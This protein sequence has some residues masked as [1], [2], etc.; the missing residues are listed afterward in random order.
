MNMH[1]YFLGIDNGGTVAK[2]AIFDET[3]AEIAIA[4]ETVPFSSPKPGFVE[5]DM[6]ALW[7]ANCRI[8]REV[9]QHS[10]IPSTHI[11][12]VACTGH[13]KGLYLW[14]KEEH[15]AYPGI[16]STDTRAWEYPLRWEKNGTAHAVYAKTFQRILACQPV[17][18]LAWLKDHAPEVVSRT[19]WI[20]EAK[21]FIRFML[22]G[23]AQAEITDYSGSG[24]LNIRDRCFDRDLL[25]AY[26]LSDIYE[27]LPP[28]VQSTALCGKISA[29]AARATGLMEGTPV[30][31]GMFD[32][33]ACAVASGV[34]DERYVGVVA[35][36]WSINEYVSKRPVTD[37][38]IMMNS[39]F[40]IPEYYLIEESSPTSAG[41]YEW[42]I[43]FFL[44]KEKKEANET[45]VSIFELAERMARSVASEECDLVFLPFLFGSN[46]NPEARACFVG[47]SAR[48]TRAH[49]IRAVLE[50]IAFSHKTHIDKL[51]A[52]RT[53]PLAIRLTGGAAKSK[54]WVQIF[55]DVIG[56]PVETVLA[57][58]PGALGC[59]MSA[60][61]AS[62]LYRDLREAV[63]HMVR[64]GER[65]EPGANATEMYQKKYNIY[66]DIADSLD[67]SWKGF[68]SQIP[69]TALPS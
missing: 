10:Q 29:S 27:K 37:G 50:G 64:R 11:A 48:H 61:V 51:S 28:L 53:P 26:G 65:I 16:V 52:T 20:F 49:M 12:A 9:L 58:E 41:N 42:F 21:D 32:I 8:I 1:H 2:A 57:S 34:I 66:K 60:A 4:S 55:A 45:G 24:L 17:S 69:S 43:N 5:R 13:G 6:L 54:A 23:E 7:H 40:C 31:G 3:G 39:L 59:A 14:G 38:S 19:K 63:S 44:D 36:T 18:L 46:Y 68:S 67:H 22:T 56:L 47:F 35:G 33:D 25:D 30:A 15:P 62:G